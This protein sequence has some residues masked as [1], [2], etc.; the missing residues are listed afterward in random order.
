MGINYQQHRAIIGCFN[1]SHSKYSMGRMCVNLY[2]D[3]DVFVLIIHMLLSGTQSGNVW[4]VCR[5]L[6]LVFYVYIICLLMGLSVNVLSNNAS[7]QF[8]TTEINP[9]ERI[10]RYER[11]LNICQHFM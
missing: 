9:T 5:F 10:Y 1:G 11:I 8:F 3:F 7:T 6:S 2:N 4:F